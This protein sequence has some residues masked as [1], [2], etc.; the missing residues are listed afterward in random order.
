MSDAGANKPRATYE[1]SNLTEELN[2]EKLRGTSENQENGENKSSQA[3]NTPVSEMSIEEIKHEKSTD[4]IEMLT[5]VTD[6]STVAKK[7]KERWFV[8]VNDSPVRL[9]VKDPTSVQKKRRKKKTSKTFRQNTGVMEKCSSLN[10]NTEPDNETTERQTTQAIFKQENVS[11]YSPNIQNVLHIQDIKCISLTGS[12]EGEEEKTS[13]P[14]SLK[15][16]A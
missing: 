2:L 12:S 4:G 13:C 11:F 15:K 8:T 6:C 16:K 5:E 3:T 1:D 10:N 9:R 14:I 7:E